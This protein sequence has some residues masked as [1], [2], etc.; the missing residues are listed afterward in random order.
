MLWFHVPSL[1]F[2]APPGQACL[3]HQ[4]NPW[5]SWL[6]V[7]ANSCAYPTRPLF[8]TWERL[9]TYILLPDS[10]R[11]F[12]WSA[13]SP[14]SLFLPLVHLLCHPDLKTSR[15]KDC[16]YLSF[17][18]KTST[19]ILLLRRFLCFIPHSQTNHCGNLLWPQV[20]H[21]PEDFTQ[22]LLEQTQ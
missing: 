6:T 18:P 11:T 22:R 19:A 13:C 16:C 3:W 8:P 17:W 7:W 1:A 14:L 20:S 10:N 15:G 2:P 4:S 5:L 12:W 21:R 9:R